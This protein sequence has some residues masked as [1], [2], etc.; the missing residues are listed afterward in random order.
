M[1]EIWWKHHK[2]VT[3]LLKQK[4][5]QSP[6]QILVRTSKTGPLGKL[7]TSHFFFGTIHNLCCCFYPQYICQLGCWEQVCLCNNLRQIFDPEKQKHKQI[8][9][10]SVGCYWYEQSLRYKIFFSVWKKTINRQQKSRFFSRPLKL[11]LFAVY[12]RLFLKSNHYFELAKYSH[13]TKL[14]PNK[15]TIYL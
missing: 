6:L 15:T 7:K 3:V 1:M 11:L 10:E 2:L 9:N 12:M 5:K 13:N 4:E 8:E 14:L